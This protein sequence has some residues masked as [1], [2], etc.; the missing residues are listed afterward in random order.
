MVSWLLRFSGLH[1]E[2]E[3]SLD[4]A[5]LLRGMLSRREEDWRERGLHVQNLVSADPIF[6]AAPAG[7]LEQLFSSI[8]RHAE[9]RLAPPCDGS[10]TVRAFHLAS[11]AQVD[12]SWPA[13]LA[14][15]ERPDPWNDVGPAA[16]DVLSLA[17]CRDLVLTQ[18]GQMMLARASD[19]CTR[20]EVELP[21]V[22]PDLFDTAGLRR[23]PSRPAAPLTTLVLEPDP[24]A[25]QV[26]VSG[27]SDLGHRVVPAASAEEAADLARRMVFHVIFCSDFAR[28]HHMARVF[29]GD[30][31]PH[32]D[33]RAADPGSGS[34]PD[35]CP[36]RR[37]RVRA[38]SAAASR[39]TG[40]HPSAS[41]GAPG[42]V[43]TL[44]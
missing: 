17:V 28:W 11:T 30:S 9:D 31:R 25:R 22:Q 24:A 29:A 44:E 7:I 34:L 23:A 43:R 42:F 33:V 26:L 16:E 20:L 36:P 14:G 18:G 27:L 2:Q 35:R 41:R 8:L 32:P 12:V 5:A 21:V 40:P 4:L 10:L 13:A 37:G 19:G 38:G 6:V 39:G 1:R 15:L 3:Q